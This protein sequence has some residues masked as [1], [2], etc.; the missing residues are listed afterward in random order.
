MTSK[1]LDIWLKHHYNILVDVNICLNNAKRLKREENKSIEKIKKEPYFQQYWY[2][3]RFIMIIQ[4]AKLFQNSGTQKITFRKLLN[5]LVN[6]SLDEIIQERFNKNIQIGD[7]HLFKS[8]NDIKETRKEI[9]ELLDHYSDIIRKL[10][11][12]RNM[13]YAHSDLDVQVEYLKFDD[14]EKLT[15]LSNI[16]FN[17]INGRFNNVTTF[18][19]ITTPWDIGYIL[20]DISKSREIRTY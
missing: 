2:H 5:R 16:I 8:V 19:E 11:N 6:E 20:Y 10:E 9:F 15:K 13:A 12:S 18:F 14:I 1:L 4:L 7:D 17:K 3:L